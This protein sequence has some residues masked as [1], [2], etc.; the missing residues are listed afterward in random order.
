MLIDLKTATTETAPEH[1]PSALAAIGSERRQRLDQIMSI[2]LFCLGAAAFTSLTLVGRQPIAFQTSAPFLLGFFP[3]CFRIDGLTVIFLSL[4]S[5]ILIAVSMFSPGYL[6]HVQ[7][8]VHGRQY[9]TGLFLFVLSMYGVVLS[10]DAITFIVLWEIM[11]L[12]SAALVASDHNRQ[13]VR[14]SAF[15]YIGATRISSAF[16][17]GGFL[18]MHSIYGSWQFSDWSFASETS[19]FPA[20]L[21][22]IAFCIKAGIWPFHIWLPYAHPAAPATVSA[23][24]SGFMIKIALYGIIRILV[25]GGLNSVNVANFAFF[26][27]A[28]SSFWGVLFALVQNDLKRLLAY[29]SIENVGLILIAIALSM[30]ARIAN[31]PEVSVLALAAAIFHCLNHGLFKTLLFLSAGSVD[32]QAHTRD[33]RK[34]GGLAKRLPWTMIC[35]FVGSFA[36]CS[37]PPLNGFASKWL[38]YQSLFKNAWQNSSIFDRGLSFFGLCLLS[39]VGGLA[40]AAFAKAMGVSFLGMP[41]SKSTVSAKEASKGMI[42]AQALLAV[43]CIGLGVS[44]N[45]ILPTIIETAR[46]AS[47]LSN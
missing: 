31:L 25:C 18:C 3:V 8:R 23:L 30:K 39:I 29:S 37:L 40:I 11:S 7:E 21:I 15:I 4:L 5:I 2:F 34:L 17:A 26:L 20:C 42:L 45:R 28:V 12:S 1:G 6:K 22:L 24:M 19:Y 35:F 33:L 10:A 14:K 16:L 46:I 32:S 47:G 9:W 44:V 27:G 43:V 13:S 36:I 41:R 38:I